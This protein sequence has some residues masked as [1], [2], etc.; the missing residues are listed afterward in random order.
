MKFKNIL[1]VVIKS[2]S[3]GNDC[4]YAKQVGSIKRVSDDLLP[5]D[6]TLIDKKENGKGLYPSIKFEDA[7]IIT[8]SLIKKF[9]YFIGSTNQVNIQ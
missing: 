5:P 7:E 4:W 3:W 2:N 6:F 9:L 1:W 8:P